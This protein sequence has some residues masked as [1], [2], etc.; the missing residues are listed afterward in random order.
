MLN[1]RSNARKT[2]CMV[3]AFPP[4]V[5]GMAAVNKAMWDALREAEVEPRVINLAAFSLNRSLRSRLGRLPRVLRGLMSL[6]GVRRARSGVGVLYMSVSGGYGQL[7]ELAFLFIARLKRM[8]IYLHH[9][10]FAYMDQPN[11]LARK[12][13]RMG[14]VN[15]TH[16]V[17]SPG[18]GATLKECYRIHNTAA[19]S[20]AVFFPPSGSTETQ[21]SRAEMK[22][23]GFISNI[24]VEKGIFE[25]LDLMKAV[26]DAGL[27]VRA[28]VAG[29]F[30]DMQTEGRVRRQL[31]KLAA[32]EYIGPK[33][34]VEKDA[35]FTTI[36]AL[37][38]PTGYINEAEPLILH[39]AMA[40][41]IPIIAYGRGC[42]PEIVGTKCGRVIDPGQPFVAEALAQVK[43]WRA[44]SVSFERASKSAQM[45]FFRTYAENQMRWQALL[46]EL[47]GHM[48]A[49]A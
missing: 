35:F 2:V 19:I 18:M 7:Y 31:A 47:T 40:R 10:S 12:L 20:N 1:I 45:R 24:S 46:C 32:V 11:K 30:Q 34:G 41:A 3:G 29:P 13:F 38:F 9:H 44:D 48:K 27:S 6:S 28:K 49:Q 16:I 5:H 26:Q 8:K 23:L 42:I 36:D 22:T 17:L 21:R 4:P 43:A 33:Y 15:A 25:F 39:E 37:V 14:G